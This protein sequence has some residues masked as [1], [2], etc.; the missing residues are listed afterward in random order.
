MLYLVVE[1]FRGGDPRPVYA[2]FAAEGRMAPPGLEYVAS[3][4]VADLTRCYQVVRCAERA[5]L[6]TWM[7]RWSDLVEFEVHTVVTSPEA[8][9]AVANL[10]TG[11]CRHGTP[12]T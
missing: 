11:S 3:W 5:L 9:A 6:E 2:R 12:A 10:D 8:A 4:V 7:A 1:H